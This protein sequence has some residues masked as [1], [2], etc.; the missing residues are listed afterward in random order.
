[1]GSAQA[2]KVKAAQGDGIFSLLRKQGL[3]PAKYYTAFVTLNAANIKNGSELHLGREYLV[4]DAPDS[5]KKMALSVTESGEGNTPI[6]NEELAQISVKS[7]DLQ[8]AVLY[9]VP[10]LNGVK[11]S[12]D[13]QQ[14][15][16]SIVKSIAQELMV[17][18]ARVYL[19]DALIESHT[20]SADNEK[21]TTESAI[22]SKAQMEHFVGAIN[23]Y[24]LQNVGKYQRVLVLNYNDTTDNQ[25]YYDV[26]VFHYQKSEEGKQLAKVLYG[27]FKQNSVG[28]T[29]ENTVGH[30]KHTNNLYLAK[31]AM[32]PVTMI[33][34]VGTKKFN[35]NQRISIRS[36]DQVLT[37]V[38]TNG[39]LTDYA[40]LSFEN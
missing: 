35:V 24:Y 33:N 8:D 16:N 18:G 11:Q 2:V 37:N 30:F 12:K 27:I 9:L 17:R 22:A 4:P 36:R 21:P 32:P 39:V 3:N 10:A 23:K 31:N 13:V 40:N 26:S 14:A 25:P 19:I 15:R 1:M 29:K 28:R 20:P 34:V 5:F 38:I 6:F 7:N